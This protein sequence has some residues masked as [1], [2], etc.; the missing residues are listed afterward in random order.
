MRPA[1]IGRPRVEQRRIGTNGAVCAP[2]IHSEALCSPDSAVSFASSVS[3]T[4]NAGVLGPTDL[5]SGAIG[6]LAG[7]GAIGAL[8]AAALEEAELAQPRRELR[9]PSAVSSAP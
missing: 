3:G 2:V 6:A 1:S 8:G 5:T 4:P 7:S 9:Q